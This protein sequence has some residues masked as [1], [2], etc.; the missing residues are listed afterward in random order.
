LGLRNLSIEIALAANN[1]NPV[2]I[3]LKTI[4]FDVIALSLRN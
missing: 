2:G 1:P 4:A 3:T